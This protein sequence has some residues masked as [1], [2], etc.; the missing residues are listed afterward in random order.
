[1]QP[2][3][4]LL[5]LFQLQKTFYTKNLD[6]INQQLTFIRA[7][8]T[9]TGTISDESRTTRPVSDQIIITNRMSMFDRCNMFTPCGRIGLDLKHRPLTQTNQT[10][11]F[12]CW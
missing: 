5:L 8:K 1:M 9:Y 6:N 2:Y 12:G 4:K 10:T 7:F 11:L 3:Y